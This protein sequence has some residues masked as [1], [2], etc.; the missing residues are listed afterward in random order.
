MNLTLNIFDEMNDSLRI[1]DQEK[2]L[3][4]LKEKNDSL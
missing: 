1:S 2:K 3:E 4:N